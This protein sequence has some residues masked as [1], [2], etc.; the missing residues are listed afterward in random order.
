MSF[1]FMH[2]Q[3]TIFGNQK[4]S[5]GTILAAKIGPGDHFWVGPIF[6]CLV[7]GPAEAN[8]DWSGLLTLVYAQMRALA[9]IRPGGSGG[10]LPQGNF[11]KLDALRRLLRPFWGLK[12][13]LEV[14]ASVLA[15]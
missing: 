1:L 9:H 2:G 7:T 4:W 12:T 11:L 14:F 3:G 6:V 13:S 15:W 10:M 5:G 8:L